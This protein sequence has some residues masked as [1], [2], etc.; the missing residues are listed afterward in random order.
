M[1]LSVTG[2]LTKRQAARYARLKG[3]TRSWTDLR[4]EGRA[5]QTGRA[6]T[7]AVAYRHGSSY[8]HSDSWSTG[9]FLKESTQVIQALNEPGDTCVDEALHI[10]AMAAYDIACTWGRFYG[11]DIREFNESAQAALD[12]GFYTDVQ[13]P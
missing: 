12:S 8:S 4:I 3:L 2:K 1:Q 9:K 10:A 11:M 5:K 6:M 13:P 7:Y